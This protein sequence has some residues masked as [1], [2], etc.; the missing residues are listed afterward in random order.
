MKTKINFL[1]KSGL[2]KNT[3]VKLNESKRKRRN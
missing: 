2:S 3:L 1:L